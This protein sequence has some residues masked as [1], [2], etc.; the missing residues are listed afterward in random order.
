VRRGRTTRRTYWLHCTLPIVAI[1][2]LAG[3]LDV[4][5]G[6]SSTQPAVG[7][8]WVFSTTAGPLGI[9]AALVNRPGES[10]DSSP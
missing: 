8:G 3:V 9:I 7:E 2:V 5:L 10:G 1:Q 4:V 6:F